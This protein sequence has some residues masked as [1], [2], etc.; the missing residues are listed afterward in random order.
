VER[1]VVWNWR[2]LM[3][4]LREYEDF[5]STH[6]PHRALNQAAPLRTLPDGVPDLDPLWVAASPRWGRESEYRLVA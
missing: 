2:H 6:R 3:T 5:C 4:V 1:T